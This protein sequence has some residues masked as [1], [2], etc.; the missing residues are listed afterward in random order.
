MTRRK[1]T[2]AIRAVISI[3]FLILPLVAAGSGVEAARSMATN[4][5]CA[6]PVEVMP[7]GDSITT[8][9]YSGP[10]PSNGADADDIGYRE[11]LWNLL[12]NA[13]N[14]VDFVGTNSN[15]SFS[16]PQHEGH[17]GWTDGQIADNIYNNGGDDFLSQN[18]P[19]VILLHIG[20]NALDT[21]PSDVEDILDEINDYEIDTG[22]SVIVIVARIINQVTHNPDVTTFNDNVAVMVAARPDY[23]TEVF[24]VDMEVG[25]G[26]IYSL[27]PAAGDMIDNLHPYATGYT[28]MAIVWKDK[29]DEIC[30]TYGANNPP[31]VDPVSDQS[32]DEGD[33]IDPLQIV[34]SDPDPNGD[35]VTYIATNLPDGLSINDTTGEISGRIGG[36]ASNGSPYHVQVT[37]GDGKPFGS[38]TIGF[39][40]T[41]SN[42][43]PEITQPAD[44]LN[45]EG[46]PVSLQIEATDPDEDSLEYS[47]LGLP[48]GLSIHASTGE[49]SGTILS[50]ASTF[51]PYTVTVTVD[52]RI[53]DPVPATFTWTVK[54]PLYFI[55]LPLVTE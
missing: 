31:N 43:P 42:P 3:G 51:S 10:D 2:W 53:A 33:M 48:T 37:A 44:Q 38:T 16:D 40:W 45:I 52:D 20:T 35:S 17:N 1:T 24:M 46:D 41:I 49:I 34:A 54:N 6:S 25:A 36:D 26:I 9:K 23:G 19:D 22:R 18:P 29:F 4:S 50:G 28:K 8:G 32:N 13:G 30:A 21:D 47:A 39:D 5:I 15:G 27:E 12:T 55:Y 7:L 11:D 14:S